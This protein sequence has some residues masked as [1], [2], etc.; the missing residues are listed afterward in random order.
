MFKAGAGS[1]LFTSAEGLSPQESLAPLQS[2]LLTLKC[3]GLKL[4]RLGG[5]GERRVADPLG[6]W[7]PPVLELHPRQAGRLTNYPQDIF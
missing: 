7:Q 2:E 5:E 4:G 6:I 1:A 3:L